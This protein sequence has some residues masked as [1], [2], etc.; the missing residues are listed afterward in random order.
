MIDAPVLLTGRSKMSSWEVADGRGDVMMN[1]LPSHREG[2]SR[3][4]VRPVAT[5]Y[6][7][8]GIVH[9]VL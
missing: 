5:V 4:V 6:G 8:F 9:P 1:R 3:T 2:T 7:V